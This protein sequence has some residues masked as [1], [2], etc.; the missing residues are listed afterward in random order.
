MKLL[1]ITQ[2]VDKNDSILGFFHGWI[3]EFSKRFEF[4][5]VICLEKGKYNLEDNVKV[6]SLGKESRVGRLGYVW[7]FYKY[8]I[9]ER[10]NYDAVFVHMNPEYIVLGG[11]LWKIFRKKISLWYTHRNVDLKLKIASGLADNIFTAS[12]ESFNLKSDKIHVMG[13]GININKF[14]NKK[15]RNSG[16]INILHVGRITKIKNIITL[17][18]SAKILKEIWDKDFRITL[19][20]STITDLDLDYFEEIKLLVS[21]YKLTD[22]INFRGNVSNDDIVSCYHNSDVVVNMT[23]TGGVDKAVLEAMASGIPVLSSNEAF[24][25]YFVEYSDILLFKERDAEDLSLK[26]KALFN[27]ND[28]DKIGEFLV[29]QAEKKASVVSL[30]KNISEYIK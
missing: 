5:T 21:K 12:K 18:D 9:S 7:S 11:L 10:K 8:I 6:L 20:G 28:L 16:V 25:D 26:I 13:H 24:R 2:K 22:I 3:D 30:I 19:V 17:I 29:A 27:N 23:P 4:V 14:K 15:T 1:I